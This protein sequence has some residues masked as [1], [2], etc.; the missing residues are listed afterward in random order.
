MTEKWVASG[1]NWMWATWVGEDQVVYLATDTPQG[2]AVMS[3]VSGS[4]VTNHLA[5]VDDL[6]DAKKLAEEDAEQLQE[7]GL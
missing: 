3:R 6:D 2:W 5:T 4:E 1:P 7:K